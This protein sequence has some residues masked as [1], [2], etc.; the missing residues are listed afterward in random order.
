MHEINL[1]DHSRDEDQTRRLA[2]TSNLGRKIDTK[3]DTKYTIYY[4]HLLRHLS[5]ILYTTAALLPRLGVQ[6]L[7]E[8][9]RSLTPNF[10]ALN[11]LHYEIFE[12]VI[13]LL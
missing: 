7:L 13:L 2:K 5:H 4:T 6:R 11:L 10:E 12:D 8:Q 3:F 1:K 9:S